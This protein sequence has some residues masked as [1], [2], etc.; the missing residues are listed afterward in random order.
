MQV[1]VMMTIKDSIKDLGSKF[2]CLLQNQLEKVEQKLPAQPIANPKAHCGAID[3]CDAFMTRSGRSSGPVLP[4]PSRA[5]VAPA[6]RSRMTSIPEE[7]E[8]NDKE[9]SRDNAK[10]GDQP[11]GND[12]EDEP[13]VIPATKNSE[14][15]VSC[16]IP[17]PD[18]MEKS[19]EDKQFSKFLETMKSVEITIPILDAVMHIPLYAKFFKELLSKKRTI[20]EPE[21]VTLTKSCSAVIQNKMPEKLGDP[22]SFCIPCTVGPKEFTAL[23]DLGSS[24]SVLPMTVQSVL[25]LGELRPTNM[26]LQLADRTIKKPVGILPDIPVLVGKFAY[27]VDFVVLEMEDNSEAVILGRPFLATAGAMIDVKGAKLT[28]QFGNE[29]AEFDMKH[30]T[31]LPGKQGQCFSIDVINQMVNDSEDNLHC[32][33]DS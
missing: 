32:Y 4:T 33:H 24:V 25:K 13:Q 10:K 1:E 28:L 19:K 9:E 6:L 22:G 8:R 14:P 18:R 23:C 12:K 20:E 30:A 29:E 7:L 2:D 21:L 26:T 16:K 31:H 17:F 27:P 15:T 11:I 3:I 5:Y